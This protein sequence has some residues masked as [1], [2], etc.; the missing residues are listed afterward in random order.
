[1]DDAEWELVDVHVSMEAPSLETR[2]AVLQQNREDIECIDTPKTA[3]FD[4]KRVQAVAVPDAM[5]FVF[6][7]TESTERLE[8]IAKTEER[9]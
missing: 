3:P 9:F 5:L 1:L 4:V 7:G 2:I 6:V 8:I